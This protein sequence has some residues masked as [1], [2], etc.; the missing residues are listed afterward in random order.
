[1]NPRATTVC[2]L[3]A[4]AMTLAGCPAPVHRESESGRF[5]S[6]L[7]QHARE[8]AIDPARP[9]TLAQCEQLALAGSLDLRIRN[10]SLG[11]Q[12]DKI[13]L[14]LVSGLPQASATFAD[15]NRS[16]PSLIK[17]GGIV[18]K[19][20]D[21]HQQLLNAGGFVPVLDFGLTYYSWRIALDGNAQELLLLRRA[22]Q[23]LRR[24]VRVAY[25]RH[26]GA[27]RQERLSAVAYSAAEQVLRVARSLE[28][29]HLTVH[30]DTALIE[31][32]LA[33]AGLQLSL[34]R[35]QVEAT[36]L[37]LSQLMSLPPAVPFRIDEGLGLIPEVPSGAQL[38]QYEE[39]ALSVR[40]ELGVQDLQRQISASQVRRDIAAFFPR[41]DMT[42]SFNW[43]SSSLVVNP[44][45]FLGGFRV[46]HALLNGGADLF[47]Y[48][49]DRKAEGLQK[50]QTLLVS[51]GILYEV[52]LQALGVRQA[53]ETVVAAQA[54]EQARKAALN[55]VISL[56]KEGLEDEAGAARALADL[57][58]ESTALD[59]AQTAYIV[60]WH[61]LEAAVLPERS[62]FSIASAS[63]P[64]SQP[65][66]GPTEQPASQ[67]ASQPA[68]QEGSKP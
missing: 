3:C 28:R 52:E 44:A 26:A 60:A 25:A 5:R 6:Y 46:T 7:D 24:D 42:G 55:R 23:L 66:T 63:Q 32:A 8:L 62:V 13:R 14:S 38:A 65:T 67:P 37:A 16:N 1:M 43:T 59:Q 48:S 61:E 39:R 45:F 22:E 20:E 10:L 31:S 50:E 18:A 33:E 47:Q 41:L 34:I 11:L 40:P 21:Q 53:R 35:Q 27:I 68:G 15:V 57:T 54:L 64:A 9:L 29:E 4:A 51:L 36:H 12:E 19:A 58:I 17:N 30:A 49:L 56:Y 2:L